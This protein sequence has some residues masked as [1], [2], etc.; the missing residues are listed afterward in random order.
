ME[1]LV[2][3]TCTFNSA[4][5]PL[6]KMV[7]KEEIIQTR[8]FSTLCVLIAVYYDV[9]QELELCSSS[10]SQLGSKTLGVVLDVETPL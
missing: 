10:I 4:H 2:T 1:N 6:I 9:L 3:F 5:S 7:D 8:Y